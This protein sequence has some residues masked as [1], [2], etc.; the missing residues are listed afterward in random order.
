MMMMHNFFGDNLFDIENW[1]DTSFD[2]EFFAKMN[3][4]Y[5]KHAKDVML[6]DVRRTEDKY[7]VVMNLP[8]FKKKTYRLT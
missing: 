5:G 7:E 2:R 1:P 4:L 6:T 3:P 8:G